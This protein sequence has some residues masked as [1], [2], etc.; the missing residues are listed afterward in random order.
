MPSKRRSVS[1]SAFVAASVALTT[2]VVIACS[3]D[4]DQGAF[5]PPDAGGEAAPPPSLGADAEARP[6]ETQDPVTCA[7]AETSKSYVGCD[8]W[9]T[10]TPNTVWSIFDFAVVVANTGAKQADVTVTGRGGFSASVSVP[11]NELRRIYLPWISELKGKDANACS[12]DNPTLE[13]SVIVPEGAYHLVSSSPVIVYQ[14]NA[15]QYQGAG[16]GAPQS[17]GSPKDWSQCP[18]NTCTNGDGGAT[19]LACLSYTNDASLLLPSTAMT[20]NYRVT[21]YKGYPFTF[22]YAGASTAIT[23]TATQP[24]TN[25]VFTASKTASVLAT[26]AGADAGAPVTGANAG[27]KVTVVLQ[28][29][30]DVVE[31]VS[32]KG[33][34]LSGSLV[35]ADKPVQVIAA[36][37]CMSIPQGTPA[38]DHLEETV[39]PAETLGKQYVIARPTGPDGTPVSHAVRIFGNQNGT[40]LTYTPN[41]PFECPAVISAGQVVDCGEVNE[42]FRVTANFEFGVATFLLGT[43]K[44]GGTE[45]LGDPSQ[46]N[47]ASIEQFRSKF[48]FLAPADYP[49]LFADITAPEDAE[50]VLD[51]QPVTA[52]WEQIPNTPFGLVRV[53]LTKSGNDGAHQLTAKRPVGVQVA[54][55]GKATSFQYPAGLNLKLIAPPPPL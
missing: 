45:R 23:V 14:F 29:A 18:G 1:V 49:K 53:D 47:V 22:G 36:D 5:T 17:N 26:A 27:G 51:G 7:E 24:N 34:D 37:P 20:G 13:G 16:D 43:E 55:Y 21:G 9:P 2:L 25:V 40:V 30:G 32:G 33:A 39:L 6:G 28:N 38:C 52:P 4:R 46:T 31:I 44:I 11:P 8:Y 15:I 41:K 12:N 48:V 50:L 42:D 10:V 3:S 54:G 19:P 35:Q